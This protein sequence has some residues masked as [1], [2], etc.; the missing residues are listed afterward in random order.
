MMMVHDQ[1]TTL[2]GGRI[3][4]FDHANRNKRSITLDV[5]KPSGRNILKK[6]LE[7]SDVLV[8]NFRESVVKRAKMDYESLSQF[9]PELVYGIITGYGSKGIDRDKRS[10][11]ISGQARSGMMFAMG[12]RDAHEPVQMQGAPLDQLGGSMLAYGILAA[13]LK[14][15]QSGKGMKVESSILG[16]G[17][18]L[19]AFS[20]NLQLWRERSLARHSRT[21]SRNPMA[22]YYECSD[23]KWLMIAEYQSDRFWHEFCATLN[24]DE[25]ENHPKYANALV[26]A[27]HCQELIQILDKVFSTRTREQWLTLFREKECQFTYEIVNSTEDLTTDPQVLTNRMIVDLDHPTMGQVKAVTSPILLNDKPMS[28][29]P[30]PEFGEHTEEV[31]IDICGY[32]WEEINHFREE[33]II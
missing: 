28:I 1:G 12:D 15:E 19:H 11:D 6:L 10:F 2:P 29:R 32:S 17:I 4:V 13:L 14:R 8:T 22:N 31:L 27:E 30:A 9:N 5:R 25:L 33:G 7:K 23:G 16:C 26:R 18:H 20:V 3:A 24:I 21:R